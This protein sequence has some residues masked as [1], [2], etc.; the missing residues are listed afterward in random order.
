[1]DGGGHRSDRPSCRSSSSFTT[2]EF[3]EGGPR[4]A[5]FLHRQGSD[6]D[7]WLPSAAGGDSPEA[8][9]GFAQPLATDVAAAAAERGL[10]VE[11]LRLEQ[12]K[13]PAH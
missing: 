11:R 10:T 6:W 7:R 4:V 13:T 1:M 9:W 12:P 2:R 3:R 5:E 8:E